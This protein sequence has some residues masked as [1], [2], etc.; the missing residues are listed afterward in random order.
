MLEWE[1]NYC[2]TKSKWR[3]QNSEAM[4]VKPSPDHR[5]GIFFKKNQKG[6]TLI[7]KVDAY[8]YFTKTLQVDD[9]VLSVNGVPCDK[10]QLQTIANIIHN[11][12]KFVKIVFNKSGDSISSF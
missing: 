1:S 9:E 10:I 3:R 11:T 2:G 4:A 12:P 8:S 5:L 6:E 7:S